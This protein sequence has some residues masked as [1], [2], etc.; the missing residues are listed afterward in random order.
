MPFF[1]TCFASFRIMDASTSSLSAI[2]V[3]GSP[4]SLD[5]LDELIAVP[6]RL[7]RGFFPLFDRVL[8]KKKSSLTHELRHTRA[9][10]HEF[11]QAIGH[12]FRAS[13]SRAQK[14]KT[15]VGLAAAACSNIRPGA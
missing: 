8:F 7:S 1:F 11:F 5:M 12:S 6:L 10:N 3:T 2:G 9:A 4:V 14:G 13:N 15:S